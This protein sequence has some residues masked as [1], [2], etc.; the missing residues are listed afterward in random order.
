MKKLITLLIIFS[1]TFT[2]V[3][4]ND[5]FFEIAFGL[6]YGESNVIHKWGKP[7]IKISTVG[8]PAEEHLKEL[9]KVMYELSDL[10]GMSFK[11]V[12]RNP[13]IRIYLINHSDFSKYIRNK[14]IVENNWGYF[15]VWWRRNN[16][17]YRSN[18]YIAIDKGTIESQLHLIR[19]ELTQCM[20]LMNDSYSYEDSIFY[21]GWG[22]IREYSEVDKTV[23]KLLYNPK[24]K[25]GM[26]KS[27]IQK[28]FKEAN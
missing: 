19:E 4:A 3:Y 17:I 28:I 5:Y 2:T 25:S 7:E 27:R 20:G 15:Y 18:I 11:T 16:E 8:D 9:N 12:D 6:E 23:I 1:L 22:T 14:N 21:Q 24:I 13:D 26:T 10:T